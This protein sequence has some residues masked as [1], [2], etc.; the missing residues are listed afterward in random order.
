MAVVASVKEIPDAIKYVR[1]DLKR[2]PQVLIAAGL[3]EERSSGRYHKKG[4]DDD[5]A[6]SK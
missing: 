1:E 3:F 6:D 4:S 5:D 2:D